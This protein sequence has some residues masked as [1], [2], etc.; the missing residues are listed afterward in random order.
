MYLF[1]RKFMWYRKT[2]FRSVISAKENPLKSPNFTMGQISLLSGVIDGDRWGAQCKEGQWAARWLKLHHP[3]SFS[4]FLVLST[5]CCYHSPTFSWPWVTVLCKFVVSTILSQGIYRRLEAALLFCN[6]LLFEILQLTDWLLILECL[7]P[8]S[9]KQTTCRKNPC[10]SIP[11]TNE[12]LCTDDHC[13]KARE[14][15]PYM[16]KRHVRPLPM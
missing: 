5:W 10:N 11:Q 3:Y 13:Y 8:F 7:S 9:K 15:K 1:L 12:H 6:S 14:F 2:D 4:I 16:E